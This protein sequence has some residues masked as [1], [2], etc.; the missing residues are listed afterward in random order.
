MAAGKKVVQGV[1]ELFES[2][3]LDGIISKIKSALDEDWF[4]DFDKVA[5]PDSL[6]VL[7]KNLGYSDDQ[8]S[9][10]SKASRLI[11]LHQVSGFQISPIGKMLNSKSKLCFSRQSGI[12]Q[13]SA[14]Y[15]SGGFCAAWAVAPMFGA[16]A[17]PPVLLPRVASRSAS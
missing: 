17:L 13:A 3:K 14:G 5:K 12:R 15:Q 8:I 1:A 2:G 9:Q 10:I 7:Q 6:E 11:V 16:A 4:D